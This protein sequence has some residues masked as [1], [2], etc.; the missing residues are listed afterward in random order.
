MA[1]AVT[2]AGGAVALTGAGLAGRYPSLAYPLVTPTR[3]IA[4][5]SLAWREDADNPLLPVFAERVLAL[6]GDPVAYWQHGRHP[7]NPPD[8]HQ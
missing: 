8:R 4:E 6:C 5:V 3:S 7:S 2:V 1:V